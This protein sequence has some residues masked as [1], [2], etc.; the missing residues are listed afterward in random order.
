MVT[1]G[2]PQVISNLEYELL[3]VLQN[4]SAALPA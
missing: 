4:K 2:N 1:T 3:T